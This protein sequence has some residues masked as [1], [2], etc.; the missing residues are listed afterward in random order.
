MNIVKSL[1]RR[2]ADWLKACGK[3][4]GNTD[5]LSVQLGCDIEE[6]VEFLKCVRVDSDGWQR[7]LERA[8]VDLDDLAKEIKTGKRIA[9]LPQ[10]LRVDALDALCDRQVTGDGVAYLA[11]F[12]K[13]TGDELVVASNEDKLVDGKPVILPGG[14]V[15]KRDGWKAPD[16]RKC[17]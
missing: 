12:D 5:Q 4:P 11:E 1:F 13:E 14:K 7:V 10:H 6:T 17:V 2:T 8:I 15:G 9:H 16:L 3:Q